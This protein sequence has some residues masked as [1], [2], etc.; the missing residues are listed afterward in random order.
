M[1]TIP[2]NVIDKFKIWNENDEYQSEEYDKRFIHALLL[3]MADEQS[4]ATSNVNKEVLEFISSKLMW[5]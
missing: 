2:K 3:V 1:F 4:L 5:E